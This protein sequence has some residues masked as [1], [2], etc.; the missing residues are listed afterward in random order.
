MCGGRRIFYGTGEELQGV[1]DVVFGSECGLANIRLLV[2]HRVT[3]YRGFGGC[4]HYSMTSV[5]VESRAYDVSIAAADIP[6]LVCDGIA[7]YED[8]ASCL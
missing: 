6:R 5:V 1:E 4:I 7:V 8:T 2:S 3:D